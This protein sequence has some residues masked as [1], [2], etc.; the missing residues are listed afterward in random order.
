ML[1]IKVSSQV[2][3]LQIS[4]GYL[5]CLGVNF[6]PGICDRQTMFATFND[7]LVQRKVVHYYSLH[8]RNQI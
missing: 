6:V 1:K 2:K 7:T 3:K 4:R 5:R 8:W